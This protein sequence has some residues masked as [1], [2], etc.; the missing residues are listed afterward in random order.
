MNL[1]K[2]VNAS[3]VAYMYCFKDAFI[4]LEK[5]GETKPYSI[6]QLLECSINKHDAE[7]LAIENGYN[8]NTMSFKELLKFSNLEPD[9]KA[10]ISKFADYVFDWKIADIY[11]K[12]DE[13]GYYD[14]LIEVDDK[15]AILAVRGSESK[16]K[17]DKFL[18]WVCADFMGLASPSTIQHEEVQRRYEDL[19]GRKV[20]DKYENIVVT[21][22][23]LGGNIAMCFAIMAAED[24]DSN[25]LD[26]IEEVV[27]L[28]NQGFSNM[29]IAK[30]KDA[31]EKCAG[32][33][34]HYEW[35]IVGSLLHEIPGSK[36]VVLKCNEELHGDKKGIAKLLYR[37]D[38]NTLY[39]DDKGN[40]IPGEKD[41]L[42]KVVG[43]ISKIVDSDMLVNVLS[44]IIDMART[45]NTS[46]EDL[47]NVFQ[48]ELGKLKNGLNDVLGGVITDPSVNLEVLRDAIHNMDNGKQMEPEILAF[49]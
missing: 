3:Q 28:D 18:D 26:K 34:T 1:E 20:L 45:G 44:K 5:R 21:G 2:Q 30:H 42:A 17:I 39:Y 41:E 49:I 10:R 4:E 6:R 35:S 40:G 11:D 22:H 8:P 37:H 46:M 43:P 9:D 31:I 47:V 14:C 32:K 19:K 48:Y 15:N 24:K 7:L 23:S 25:I 13:T 33:L 29:F 38:V 12:N 36:I 27:G 16:R